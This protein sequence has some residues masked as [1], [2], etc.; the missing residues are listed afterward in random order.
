MEERISLEDIKRI[1]TEHYE[2]FYANKLGNLDY[3][4]KFLECPNHHS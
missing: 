2:Q 3:M 4:R 1:I